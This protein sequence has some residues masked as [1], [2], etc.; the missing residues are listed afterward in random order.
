VI[1]KSAGV[2]SQN[3]RS[4]PRL[5]GIGLFDLGLGTI[6]VVHRVMD[7]WRG[8]VAGVDRAVDHGP[9]VHGRSAEGGNPRSNPGLRSWIERLG[10]PARNQ[11]AAD[12]SGRLDA[13]PTA[14]VVCTR[15]DGGGHAGGGGARWRL[16]GDL[17]EDGILELGATVWDAAGLYAELGER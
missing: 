10:T 15:R 12:A 3:Y 2:F 5:A 6:S 4:W 11:V 13:D 16:T 14:R 9:R 7:G 1:L 17:A 8:A